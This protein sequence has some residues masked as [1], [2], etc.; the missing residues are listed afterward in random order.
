MDTKK[1]QRMAATMY[2]VRCGSFAGVDC[3]KDVLAI[4]DPLQAIVVGL[5]LQTLLEVLVIA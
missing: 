1:W 2:G 3:A 5:A 4:V